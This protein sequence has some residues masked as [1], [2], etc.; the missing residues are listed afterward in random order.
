MPSRGSW[1][2]RVGRRSLGSEGLSHHPLRTH[3]QQ[4]GRGAHPTA[5]AEHTPEGAAALQAPER[6]DQQLGQRALAR[7][8]P[9]RAGTSERPWASA[10]GLL[11]SL[12]SQVGGKEDARKCSDSKS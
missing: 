6:E 11:S 5:E 12:G 2:G 1:Q 10:S 3:P 7:P 8:G 4:G 9:Q